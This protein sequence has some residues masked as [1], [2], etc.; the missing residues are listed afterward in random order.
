M[1]TG[2]LEKPL[3]RSKVKSRRQG[4][5]NVSY[6]EGWHAISEANRIFGFD[7][8]S[9]NTM[10]ITCVSERERLVGKSQ[11]SGWGVTYTARVRVA[12]IHEGHEVV[13][14]GMGAGH[15]IGKDLGEC[16]ESAIKEAETDAMKR[17]LMT[18]G[19]PFGLALYDKEQR[20]VEDVK[21]APKVDP[22][23]ANMIANIER[24]TEGM[25]LVK[26]YNSEAFTADFN[27][28]SN[29]DQLAVRKAFEA[30]EQTFLVETP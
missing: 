23:A 4:G 3:D 21:Q 25:R 7:G 8:W 19:N 16:H 6:I 26:M 28:L 18:F 30:K 1:K 20:E 15:G 24:Q 10:E 5:V 17:A 12:V 22:V 13:R 2:E 29:A 14:D 27:R 9:R 11:E